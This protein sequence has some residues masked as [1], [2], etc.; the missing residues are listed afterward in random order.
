MGVGGQCDGEAV[1]VRLSWMPLYLVAN[2]FL[3]TLSGL[4]IGTYCRTH[5][6]KTEKWV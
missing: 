2:I 4:C 3:T 1:E 5:H 6:K